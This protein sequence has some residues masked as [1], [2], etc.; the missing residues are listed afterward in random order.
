MTLA[1]TARVLLVPSLMLVASTSCRADDRPAAAKGVVEMENVKIPESTQWHAGAYGVA[2]SYIVAPQGAP[3][4]ARLI[5]VHR[6]EE[7]GAER[8]QDVVPGDEVILGDRVL[9]VSRIVDDPEQGW[10]ELKPR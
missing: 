9:I 7:A 5:I 10:I 8:S 2:V 4:K 1:S 3:P 6:G